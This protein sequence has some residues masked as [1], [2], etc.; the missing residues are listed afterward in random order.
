MKYGFVKTAAASPKISVANPSE[1]AKEII[2]FVKTACLAKVDIL[3]FPELCVSGYTCADLFLSQTLL[4]SVNIALNEICKFSVGKKILFFVGAPIKYKEKLFSCAVA[5]QN[6]KILGIVP[7]TAIPTYGEFYELRH[8]VSGQD[9]NALCDTVNLCEQ[10]IPFGT[11]IIFS[12]KK[13]VGV[14]IAVEICE[15]MFVANP[16]SINHC[17]A[18]ANIIVNLSASNEIVGKNDYRKTLIK[19]QS[20]RLSAGYVYAS[21][22]EGENVSDVIF[23]G[24]RIIA[25]NGEILVQSELFNAGIAIS[26]IDVQRLGFERQ[27]LNTFEP[28]IS[29]NYKTIPFVFDDKEENIVRSISK[30]PFVPGNEKQ[31]NQHAEL[32]LRMQA[33]ALAQKLEFTNSNAV[34]GVSGGIDSC[35]ALLAIIRSYEILKRDKKNIIA[36]TMPGVGTSE[37]TLKNVSNLAKYFEIKITEISISNAVKDHLKNINHNGKADIAFENAQARERTQILMDLANFKNGLVVGTGDLSEIALGWCTYGGDHIA[38]YNIN[39]GIPKTLVKYLVSYEA[40]RVKKYEKVLTDIL[41]TEISPELLPAKN[42]KT[43]QKTEQILGSYVLHDFFL[44][45]TIRFGQHPKKTFFLALKAFK[46]EFCE[47]EIKRVFKI[48][49]QRFFANQFKRNCCPDGV[50][51]GSV[52][53]SPRGDLRMPS[54]INAKEWLY[55]LEKFDGK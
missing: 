37:K 10:N 46:G 55:E 44:Y 45:Y 2:K 26:E 32:I 17:K 34:V 27:K 36:L 48:F 22:G 31:L 15:D 23:S 21:C 13:D 51:I 47:E 20:G 11:N 33:K 12:D 8:F 16:P 24:S 52:S 7:K 29:K 18:G 28:C 53:L 35:L 41:N 39:S 43:S 42:G 19:A 14:K 38:M 4:N 9:I 3:V 25:E 30:L 49:I 54:E 6:N 5:F 1:N 50:K 40:Q